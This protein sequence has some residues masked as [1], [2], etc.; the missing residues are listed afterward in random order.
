VVVQSLAYRRNLLALLRT[1]AELLQE[2]GVA[3]Q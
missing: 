1:T 3:I 2:R